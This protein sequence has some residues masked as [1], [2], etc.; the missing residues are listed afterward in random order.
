M[1]DIENIINS[2]NNKVENTEDTNTTLSGYEI[3]T[4]KYQIKP[5]K[6][7][8]FGVGGGGCNAVNGMFKSGEV[9]NVEFVVANTDMKSLDSC[10]VADKILL[11]VETT[12]GCGAGNDPS[13][14]KAAAEESIDEIE[15]VLKDTSLLFLTAG[16][17]GG[18]GTGATPVIAK[19]AK[20]MGIS[21]A[22]IVTKPYLKEGKRAMATAEDG[23]KALKPYVDTLIIVPNEN[24][25]KISNQDTKFFDAM[26]KVD[27]VLKSGV[28]SITDLITKQ[29]FI[30]LDLADVKKAMK[31]M[32]KAVMGT[33]EASGEGR[34]IRAA[35]EAICNPLLDSI[36]MKTAKT[37]IVSI[38][39]SPD[40][41]M[42][43]N[44][45]IM[46]RVGQ[47]IN[48]D[49]L[50]LSGNSIDEDMD[51]LIRV[52]IFATGIDSEEYE[53][54]IEHDKQSERYNS[55]SNFNVNEDQGGDV[56]YTINP[57][58]QY[59]ANFSN[60]NEED[61][62]DDVFDMGRTQRIDRF[63]DDA[64]ANN[65]VVNNNMPKYNNNY[66]VADREENIIK[67][68]QRQ[69]NNI[70]QE[71][72]QEPRME[73]RKQEMKKEEKKS[74]GLFGFFRKKEHENNVEQNIDTSIDIDNYDDID[75]DVYNVPA[76]LR[77]GNKN[78]NK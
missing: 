41:T 1:G 36:S 46:G 57:A 15:A 9:E 26:R 59:T 2:R 62:D 25:Y 6:I 8:V 42:F 72:Y 64:V 51:D 38:C 65:P 11:G 12:N 20:E 75:I 53:A 13:V 70:Q 35:E 40:L 30:G 32:G 34:A 69:Y 44:D 61:E 58:E 66:V 23:I 4:K 19:K 54:E 22:A 7:L 31:D 63:S 60:A 27:D 52:S 45:Q 43:E 16:M 67:P 5:P 39:A 50:I 76:Y 14:A 78:N 74:G 37:V 21:V 18:T 49:A 56:T 3:L 10:D 71:H 77:N 48:P 29:G 28:K 73:Q 33:G 55:T 47:E 68:Q 17:G 24:L